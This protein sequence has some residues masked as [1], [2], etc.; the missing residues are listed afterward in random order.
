MVIL[1]YEVYRQS[2][3]CKIAIKVLYLENF[4]C[5]NVVGGRKSFWLYNRGWTKRDHGNK[6]RSAQKEF[7]CNCPNNYLTE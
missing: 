3:R 7:A 2:E 5:N 6:Q 4:R 1:I